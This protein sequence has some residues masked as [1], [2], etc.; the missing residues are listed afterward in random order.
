[1]KFNP[2]DKVKVVQPKILQSPEGCAFVS[3]MYG[4]IDQELTIRHWREND[5]GSFE[6]DKIAK[7]GTHYKCKECSWTWWEG[8]LEPAIPSQHFD[9][10]LFNI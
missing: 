4:Y 3:S 1:M 9:E 2:G 5:S 7:S 8:W 6:H 10:E